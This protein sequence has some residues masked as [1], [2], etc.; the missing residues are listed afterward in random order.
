MKFT[1]TS[2]LEANCDKSALYV[3]GMSS[4]LVVTLSEILN[5]P[6]GDMPF[7]YLRIPL[8]H[9]KLSFSQCLP[10]VERM[11]IAI[12]KWTSRFLS[13]AAKRVLTK[14]AL[15]SVKGFWSQVFLLP[16]KIIKKIKAACRQFLLCGG[17][18][19][20]DFQRW[21]KEAILKQL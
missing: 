16:K 17:F 8:S 5:M 9:K 12:K 11:I 14:S 4:E 3:R 6:I 1:T 2:G 13:Y 20:K 7:R 19:V 10:L 21:N 15:S 18:R